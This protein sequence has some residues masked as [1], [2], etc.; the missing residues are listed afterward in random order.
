ML[1]AAGCTRSSSAIPNGA[2]FSARPMKGSTVK[3]A[4]R[5][6]RIRLTPVICIGETEAERDGR[7]HLFVLDKQLEKGLEG[8]GFGGSGYH[9]RGLRTGLGHRHREN[10]H[11]RSGAGSPCN[12][13]DRRWIGNL[14][15]DLAEVYPNP[16]RR[17]RQT[18]QCQELMAMPDMDGALVGGASLDPESFAQLVNF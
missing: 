18:G 3:S 6:F 8:F 11:H 10:R 2:S 13:S 9:G 12:S 17:Q 14:D 5:H 1:K 16:V 7:R 4:R 15:Q